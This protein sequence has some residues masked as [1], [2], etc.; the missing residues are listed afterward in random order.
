[1]SRTLKAALPVGLWGSQDLTRL[2]SRGQVQWGP[3]VL[4]PCPR[5]HP[6]ASARRPLGEAPAAVAR[7]PCTVGAPPS[8]LLRPCCGPSSSGVVGA[9]SGTWTVRHRQAGGGSW[10]AQPAPGSLPRDRRRPARALHRVPT[11]CGTARPG[12]RPASAQ[13]WTWTRGVYPA[14]GE[15]GGLQLPTPLLLS[16]QGLCARVPGSALQGH[17]GPCRDPVSQVPG[18]GPQG[19]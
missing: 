3:P 1:M 13:H 4:G 16:P 11:S 12:G 5:Q 18:P 15:E 9:A 19:P 14:S 2:P 10:S 17:L 7:L 6:R 8:W